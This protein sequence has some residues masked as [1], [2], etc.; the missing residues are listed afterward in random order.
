[1]HKHRVALIAINVVFLLV[2]CVYQ[3]DSMTGWMW[4]MVLLQMAI[5]WLCWGRLCSVAKPIY[6]GDGKLLSGGSDV[7][8]GISEY[9]FDAIYLGLTAQIGSMLYSDSFFWLDVLIPIYAVYKL[10]TMFLKP[11][12]FRGSS[13]PVD[14]LNALDAKRQ[15]RQAKAR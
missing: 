8:Y 2:R 9:F 11:W 4:V 10:W 12:F 5:H 14:Q 6:D 3:N 15:A 7:H 13:S 1:M